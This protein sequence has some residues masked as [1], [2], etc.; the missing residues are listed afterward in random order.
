M[1]I[2]AVD[3]VGLLG[4]KGFFSMAASLLAS[5]PARTTGCPGPTTGH[6]CLGDSGF[7]KP[8]WDAEK[9]RVIQ[10]LP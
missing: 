1:N 2:P 5:G 3:S 10:I 7:A 6:F 9:P 8:Q 4:G